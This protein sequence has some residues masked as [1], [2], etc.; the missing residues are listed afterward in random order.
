VARQSEQ[1]AESHRRMASLALLVVAAG[2]AAAFA[3]S[4]VTAGGAL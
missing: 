4:F 3:W 2:A 1:T